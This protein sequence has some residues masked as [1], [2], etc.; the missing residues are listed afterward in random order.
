VRKYLPHVIVVVLVVLVI[1]GYIQQGRDAEREKIERAAHE[2]LTDSLTVALAGRIA[3]VDTLVDTLKVERVRVV[4]AAARVDTV[5]VRLPAADASGDSLRMIRARDTIIAT[6]DTLIREQAGH[7][8]TLNE[9]IKADSAVVLVYRT[10]R[11]ADSTRIQQLQKPQ[12]LRIPVLG[13]RLKP[14]C[15]LGGG[16]DV[17]PKIGGSVGFYCVL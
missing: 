16:L 12:G 17:A 2:K 15:G 11:F 9:V 5:T 13:I 6:Q 3:K 7:I 14:K 1:R 10:Q 4:K 8:V